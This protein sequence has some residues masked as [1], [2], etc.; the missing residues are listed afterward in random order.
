MKLRTDISSL[1]FGFRETRNSQLEFGMWFSNISSSRRRPRA[2][3]SKLD[4][5]VSGGEGAKLKTQISSFE[6]SL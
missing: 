1:E 4:S 3:N 5:G 6:F 2:P